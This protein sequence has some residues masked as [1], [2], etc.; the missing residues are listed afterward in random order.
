MQAKVYEYFL[1]NKKD[2]LICENDKEA[3]TCQDALKFLGFETYVLP[4][5]RA[6]YGDDLRSY[7]EELIGISKE[8]SGYYKSKNKNKIIISPIKTILK[9]LPAK[10]HLQIKSINF[11]D[12]IN[13]NELKDEIIRFG[14]EV[15]DIVEMSGEVSFR[16]EIIDIFPVGENE[17]YRILLDEDLVES[18]R[19]FDETTQI[20]EK[21]EYESVEISPFI[22]SLSE[23]EYEKTT[24]EI[25]SLDTN[26]LISDLNSLGFWAIDD[27][28][29]Y[30]D[31]FSHI[32]VKKFDEDE[33]SYVKNIIKKFEII[34]QPI[35]FKD[36]DTTFSN[37]LLSFHKEKKIKIL[38]KNSAIF[39]SLE[40]TPKDNL[41][42]I[43]SDLV[44]N[45]ISKDELVISLN[46]FKKKKRVKKTSIIIDELKVGDFVVHEEYGVG[47]FMGLELATVMGSQREFVSIIYQN[48]DKLLLPVENL[49]MIDRYIAS[50]VAILDR[51]GKGSFAKIKEKVRAKLFAIASKIIEIAAKREL[52]EGKII[53]S[54]FVEYSKFL[55][56]AGFEYTK[57]QQTCVDAI[58]KDLKSGKVMDRLVSGDVGFGK[59]EI[60]MNAIFATVK[61]GYQALFFVPTT[62]LSSQHYQSLVKR[63]EDFN[64]PV[65]R[66]DRFTTTAGKNALKKALFDKV[67]LVCVGTHSL[68]NLQA[69]NIGLI[70]ID[71]EHKFGVKQK[72][73]LKAISA[74][75][76]L[77]SISATPIPRSLNM[78]LSS[79]K[80]Y[81]T[82]ATPPS[83]R[84]DVRTLV[85]EWDEKV[86][87][88][89]ISRELRRGGQVFYVHNRIS[90]IDEVKKSLLRIFPNLKI[91]ILHSQIDMKTT[92]LEVEKFLNKE[93]D[94]MLCTSIV[95]SGIHMPN[96]N[97]IIIENANNFGIA[98]LHQLRGRVGR[99][100]KQGYCYYLIEDK[101]TLTQDSLKRLVALEN[102]S[103][104]GS[105]SVLAY[106]DLEIRGGGN[107]VGEAQSGHI[108]AI[109]YSLYLKML[110]D[111]INALLNKK[112]KV[113][114]SV[115]MKL[116][117]NAFLNSEYIKEDRIR[118]ELYRRLSKAN[119]VNEIYEISGEM[120]DRFGKPDVYTK[121]FLDIMLIKI[122]AN[123]LNIKSISNYEMNI[124]YVKFDDS[125]VVLKSRSKDDDDIID[126]LLSHLRKELKSG[127]V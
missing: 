58:L 71:E 101:N 11:G 47:K 117:I 74:N 22:A 21:K 17:P 78:A 56:E 13:L 7:Y 88:E 57:D 115:D 110:E 83:D 107:L 67:P 114:S 106:H 36:F 94:L 100:D 116:S 76:H 34:P 123:K 97:T 122:M 4:D 108:E 86:I 14:Y 75:S 121:Q 81:S 28:I 5:F 43:I 124:S 38:A 84:L 127:L 103:F 68:L 99:S 3:L 85:K 120:E 96:A 80:S 82:L 66:L 39:E 62:L 60:A 19:V 89:A 64:I 44:I 26:S 102:N 70:V 46:K 90:T 1:K 111:E 45:L 48:N 31:S 112:A 65:F 8:L 91:L 55:Q 109:G 24:K 29:D 69:N 104:L 98:D 113:L 87:K 95:E 50:G 40:L 125:K 42:L 105:G 126:T 118:L 30:L 2:I 52:V 23:D 27:F 73:K 15:V 93:Y 41:E 77:L 53:K 92:E 16:G 18:I 12:K 51:L 72:E 59:T 119:E 54:D 10:K 32:S 49:N 25:E 6:E 20:S 35:N 33:F 37:E 9:K 61:S 63:F 79:I